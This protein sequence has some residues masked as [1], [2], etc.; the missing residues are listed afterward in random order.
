MHFVKQVL[1]P[2]RHNSYRPHLIR[3]HGLAF[4]LLLIIASQIGQALQTDAQPHVLG[5]ASNITISGLLSSTN[6]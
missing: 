5:Y 1:I 3:R 2:H 6:S 4:A